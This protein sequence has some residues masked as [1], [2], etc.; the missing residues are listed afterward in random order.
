MMQCNGQNEFREI[1]GRRPGIGLHEECQSI[2][3]AYSGEIG[4]RQES[5]VENLHARSELAA[6]M[7]PPH[8]RL[9]D[10]AAHPTKHIYS[11]S[12][13]LSQLVY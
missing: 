11:G 10:P 9:D 5:F 13:A 8:P 3:S 6:A 12:S 1:G 4:L 2:R 7:A